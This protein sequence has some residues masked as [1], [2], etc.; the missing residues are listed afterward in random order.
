MVFRIPSRLTQMSHSEPAAQA[1]ATMPVHVPKRRPSMPM[2]ST[3]AT[4]N[5]AAV[6]RRMTVPSPKK[7][8]AAATT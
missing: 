3:P 5:A 1:A 8:K 6:P 4:P 7:W 2:A